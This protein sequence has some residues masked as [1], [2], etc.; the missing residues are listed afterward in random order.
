MRQ[1]GKHVAERFSMEMVHGFYH[2][3]QRGQPLRRGQL[4]S[5][6]NV[7]RK[8]Y[9]YVWM[10]KNYPQIRGS[11]PVPQTFVEPG[12]ASATMRHDQQGSNNAAS[13]L[14]ACGRH[15]KV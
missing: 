13:S 3:L 5:L 14:C 9:I 6:D 7:I 15:T 1:K 11:V 8:W 10:E 2:Q 12:F 4:A